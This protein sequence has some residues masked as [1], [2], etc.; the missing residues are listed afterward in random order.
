[1]TILNSNSELI[2]LEVRAEG[3]H[4]GSKAYGEFY[5]PLEL[6][7]LTKEHLVGR[8]YYIYELDGKHSEVESEPLTY[9]K[10]TLKELI[11]NSSAKSGAID[12]SQDLDER[13]YIGME[14]YLD[15][16]GQS[17]KFTEDLYELAYEINSLRA[18]YLRKS[19][20]TIEENLEI[21]DVELSG[22][23]NNIIIPAGTEI[24]VPNNDK[25]EY[26]V[27]IKYHNF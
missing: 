12:V 20:R 19:R 24:I 21:N 15:E 5:I 8:T 10:V 23:L 6:F 26:E 13:I 14:E 17:D 7:E 16:K 4:S 27:K 25:N 18:E 9:K 22:I 1:M 2:K 11:E 3:Y